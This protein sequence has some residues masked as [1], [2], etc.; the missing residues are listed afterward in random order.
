MRGA[1]NGVVTSPLSV[2]TT[3]GE[4]SLGT[5]AAAAGE[6]DREGGGVR[7]ASFDETVTEGGGRG[8]GRLEIYAGNG[9][10]GRS[11]PAGM[12]GQPNKSLAPIKSALRRLSNTPASEDSGSSSDSSAGAGNSGGGNMSDSR[13][14]KSEPA[15]S[16]AVN[17]YNEER[18]TE[19]YRGPSENTLVS[20]SRAGS[21]EGRA[22]SVGIISGEGSGK[23]KAR[24]EEPRRQSAGSDV[25]AGSPPTQKSQ[26]K[27]SGSGGR[28]GEGK[29]GRSGRSF[30][31]TRR[32][33]NGPRSQSPELDTA[34]TTYPSL[35][36]KGSGGKDPEGEEGDRSLTFPRRNRPGSAG[37]EQGATTTTTTYFHNKAIVGQMLTTENVAIVVENY[38]RRPNSHFRGESAPPFGSNGESWESRGGDVGGSSGWSDREGEESDDSMTPPGANPRR[39]SA[40]TRAGKKTLLITTDTLDPAAT[41]PP[42]WGPNRRGTVLTSATSMTSSNGP[43]RSNENVVAKKSSYAP[44]RFPLTIPSRWLSL[45]N[46]MA[47]TNVA[48]IAVA[49]I[50]IAVVS[51]LAGQDNAN[52]SLSVLGHVAIRQVSLSMESALGRAE[53]ICGVMPAAVASSGLRPGTAGCGAYFWGLARGLNR[54]TGDQ[55][56]L[57]DEQGAFCGVS[58]RNFTG[59]QSKPLEHFNLTE[60]M[61]NFEL[62]V[63]NGSAPAPR[64]FYNLK[65]NAGRCPD[66]GNPACVEALLNSAPVAQDLYDATQLPYYRQATSGQERWTFAYDLGSGDGFGI[67]NF[68]PI[69]HPFNSSLFLIAAVDIRLQHLSQFFRDVV[70]TSMRSRSMSDPSGVTESDGRA[71]SEL[72]QF[73]VVEADSMLVLASTCTDTMGADSTQTASDPQPPALLISE[74]NNPCWG[75]AGEL[76]GSFS[77]LPTEIAYEDADTAQM[78]VVRTNWIGDDIVLAARFYPRP[79]LNWI[80]IGRIPNQFFDMGLGRAFTLQIP[81]TAG[82]VLLAA[83]LASFLITRAIGGPL[84]K[85]AE[86]MMRIANLNFDE[87]DDDSM[88]D[89]EYSDEDFV[90]GILSSP[91]LWWRRFSTSSGDTHSSAGG[92]AADLEMGVVDRMRRRLS[93]SRSRSRRR[94][95]STASRKGLDGF[96][97]KE[98]RI[99]NTAMNAMTSGLK[100]FSKYVPLEVVA[101][102]VKMQREAVLGVDEMSLSVFFSDIANFTTLAERMPPQTLVHVMSDYLN[103]M[104]NIILDSQGIVDKFIGDAVMAFWNAPLFLKDHAIVACGAALRSQSRLRELRDDWVRQGFPEIRA[105]IGINTGPALVGNLGSPTRLNYTCLGDTVNL[106]SRLEGLNKRYNT[107]IIVSH[108]VRDELGDQYVLR[109]LDYVAVKGKTVAVKCYELIDVMEG[110]DPTVL[111]RANLYTQAFDLYCQSQFEE[112]K[113][114]FERYLL[115]VP[116]DVPA[117]MHLEECIRLAE[118]GVPKEWSPVVVLEEK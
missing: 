58:I 59:Y 111:A 78:G 27:P 54:W 98:I 49:I 75:K 3:L 42:T 93:R 79:G 62:R 29:D 10:F 90:E 56:Y 13:I 82:L 9:A 37:R 96:E 76:V 66:F 88:S 51:Y 84:K 8:R 108:A 19:E 87:D 16:Q 109:P 23:G 65:T 2:S 1:V 116:W 41:E 14:S 60:G 112:A 70:L 106:A 38:A 110:C 100:S 57:V 69:L 12:R 101:L 55:F 52:N 68:Y 64:S 61:D 81:L 114:G 7:R 4:G 11:I 117:N 67:T 20:S 17:G 104:S 24:S 73:M 99:L 83:G 33:S 50:I 74:L 28:E 97:L 86:K 77:S 40:P 103:E 5:P 115:D 102:L 39:T 94:R 47:V 92:R 53:T 32:K 6:E 44:W 25:I 48:I 43:W 18:V 46:A 30:F 35:P 107:S 45:R 15:L 63:A 26:R 85:A 71:S 31:R 36:R 113:I 89:E 22:P 91:R 80:I 72:V 95:G 34:A 105:R 118:E 21:V